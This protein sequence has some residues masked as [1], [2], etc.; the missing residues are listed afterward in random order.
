MAVKVLFIGNV[1]LLWNWEK[2]QANPCL[3][4]HFWWPLLLYYQIN[5]NHHG[6]S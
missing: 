3:I 1:P 2:I 4:Y 5:I 6:F